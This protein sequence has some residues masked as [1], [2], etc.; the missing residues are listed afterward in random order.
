MPDGRKIVFVGSEAGHARRAWVQ[1]LDGGKARP[2][3][4]EGVVGAVLSP[5]GRFV[6][7]SGPDQKVGLYPVEGGPAR[8]MDGLDPNDQLLAWSRDQKFLYLS[9]G[10]RRSLISRIY[11][12]EI[13]T[14]RRELW[15]NFTL[16]DPTGISGISGSA[17]TP[18]GKA[19]AFTYSQQ[20]SDLYI[21]YGLK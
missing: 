11:R 1:D 20:F 16:P 18:D 3:T 19:F 2:V 7:A 17:I 15:K 6:A 21:V 13:S 12:F 4:P 5:D 10:Y 14:G 9:W 8:L